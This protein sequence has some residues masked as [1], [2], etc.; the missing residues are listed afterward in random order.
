MIVFNTIPSAP[1]TTKSESCA[2][3]LS[4]L[5]ERQ[6]CKHIM[7]KLLRSTLASTDWAYFKIPSSDS[8]LRYPSSPTIELILLRYTHCNRFMQAVA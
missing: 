7:T 8:V 6:L 3:T 1:K 2:S 5:L 4:I